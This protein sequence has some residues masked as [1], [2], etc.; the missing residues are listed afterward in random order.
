MNLM[1]TV[2]VPEFQNP[3]GGGGCPCG[4]FF[5]GGGGC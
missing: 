1:L 4:G 2:V 5:L 3:M